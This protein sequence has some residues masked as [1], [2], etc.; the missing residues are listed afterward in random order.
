MPLSRQ[1]TPP[2][3]TDANESPPA[4]GSW[5]TAAPVSRLKRSFDS[6]TSIPRAVAPAP[7]VCNAKRCSALAG[8]STS[9]STSNHLM[10]RSGQRASTVYCEATSSPPASDSAN[11]IG[12]CAAPR[13]SGTPIRMGSCDRTIPDCSRIT[14][15][16][17]EFTDS[18]RNLPQICAYQSC[19]APPART[20]H[21]AVAGWPPTNSHFPCIAVRGGLSARPVRAVLTIQ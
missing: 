11:L 7:A 18:L 14:K 20:D 16:A 2:S 12:S 4:R 1:S 21:R 6:R 13:V 9:A 10:L 8:L 17:R 5:K 15:V 3:M 19:R